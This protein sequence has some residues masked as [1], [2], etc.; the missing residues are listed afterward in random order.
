MLA[1]AAELSELCD[2]VLCAIVVLRWRS[3]MGV[4]PIV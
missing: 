4:Q 3:R 2:L 1:K